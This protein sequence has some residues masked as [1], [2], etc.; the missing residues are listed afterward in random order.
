MIVES[1]ESSA[2]EAALAALAVSPTA[3]IAQALHAR[4]MALE[5]LLVAVMLESPP[6]AAERVRRGVALL[7]R[8]Y[9]AVQLDEV[10]LREIE[11]LVRRIGD[12]ADKIVADAESGDQPDV[13]PIR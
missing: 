13:S 4:Q 12:L 10:H 11:N 3:A 9:E 1:D 2:E 8:N 6:S 5:A 7:K